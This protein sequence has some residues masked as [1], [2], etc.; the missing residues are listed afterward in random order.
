MLVLDLPRELLAS[1]FPAVERRLARRPDAWTWVAARGKLR[2]F[3]GDPGG[4]DDLHQ[5]AE[6]YLRLS[7]GRGQSLLTAA[8]LLRLAGSAEAT[9]VLQRL[10]AQ[11]E[12]EVAA[13]GHESVRGGDLIDACFLL[14]DDE[15]VRYH[16]AG[17]LR[18]EPSGLGGT[19]YPS[20]GLLAGRGRGDVQACDEAVAWFDR[21]VAREPDPSGTGGMNGHDWLEIAL[22]VRREVTGVRSD[23]LR[24]LV[25]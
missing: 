8:N 1:A 17:L 22:V 6:T 16:L 12:A 21:L 20:V 3:L 15:A 24:E 23:R 9:G 18:A 13:S 19:R 14:R 10:R 25:L 4:L 11:Q 7:E 5:A 2:R